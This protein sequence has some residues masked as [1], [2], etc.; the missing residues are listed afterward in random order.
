MT[1]QY[2]K[3]PIFG[4]GAIIFEGDKVLLAKRG[5]KPLEGAWSLPGGAQK[6]GETIEAA[7]KREIFEETGLEIEVIRFAAMITPAP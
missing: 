2:P 1:R 4:V 5:R 6:L 7:L 3:R